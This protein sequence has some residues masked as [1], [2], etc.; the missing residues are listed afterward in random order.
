LYLLS[1]DGRGGF[2]EAREITLPGAVTAMVTGDINR[3]DGLTDLIVGVAATD[4]PRVMVFE[5]PEGALRSSPEVFV[6]RS[7]VTSLVVG[8]LDGD[9]QADLAIAAGR[10]LLIVSGRDRKL[11]LN[12]KSRAEVKAAA[13]A[14]RTFTFAIRSIA[15]GDF[16]GRGHSD[17]ALMS[18]DGT[19]HFLSREAKLSKESSP[20]NLNCWM[21]R[22]DIVRRALATSFSTGK[23]SYLRAAD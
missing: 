17:L 5:G 13:I 1:G 12:D 15:A 7:P 22:P 8:H 14:T 16:T 2:G 4:G 20:D 18:N 19:V 3:P 23:R 6:T 11:S 21:V 9:Q 10:E